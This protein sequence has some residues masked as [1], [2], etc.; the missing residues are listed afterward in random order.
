MNDDPI[1]AIEYQPPHSGD[2]LAHLHGG[3]YEGLGEHAHLWR[4]VRAD[5]D[6]ASILAA[7]DAVTADLRAHRMSTGWDPNP[8]KGAS[9]VYIIT[10]RFITCN[11]T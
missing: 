11:E 4:A 8:L 1:P 7:L 3:V 2:F 6:A 9:R 5:P 10:L